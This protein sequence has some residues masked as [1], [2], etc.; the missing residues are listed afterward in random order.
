M[1]TPWIK[2]GQLAKAC[3]RNEAFWKNEI[4]EYPLM[5]I[6]AP[7]TNGTVPKLSD[8]SDINEKWTNVDLA[9]AHAENDLARTYFA[10]DA[11]P[12]F[13]PW[14]GPDQ[15][16][17]WLGCEM[18]LR[19]AQLTSWVKPFVADWSKYQQFKI[20]SSNKWWRLYLEIVK[21][22][23]EAGRHKWVTAYP[24]L[25]CGIDGLAAIRGPENLLMDMLTEPEMLIAPMQEMTRLFKYV[26]DRVSESILPAGQ[27]TS[28]WTMGWSDRRFMCIGHND[29]TCMVSQELFDKFCKEDTRKCIE[30]TDLSIYH[31]D[32]PGQIRHLDRLLEIPKL[33]C[34]QWIQGAGSPPPSQWLDLLCRIQAAG[35]SVQVYYGHGDNANLH[36]EIEALCSR[37]DPCGLFIWASVHSIEEA[38]TLVQYTKDICKAKR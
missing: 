21:A 17:A 28:N 34:I 16:A 25:H 29:V 33:N 35:K 20:D 18:E 38:D 22:S 27:G 6:T 36:K 11:L 12:V 15:F 3:L 4:E 26:F 30:Y 8:S 32:G 9:I 2:E 24:D 10:G 13:N 31:L 7:D 1:Q 19:V 23:V 37:L 5:W 14:F